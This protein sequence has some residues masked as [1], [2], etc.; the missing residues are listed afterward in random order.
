MV[1][2]NNISYPYSTVKI[3][4][5]YSLAMPSSLEYDTAR[6]V[7]VLAYNLP[8]VRFKKNKTYTKDQFLAVVFHSEF[9]TF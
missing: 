8:N 5:Q 9:K 7:E 2:T 6:C 4:I 1:D 3:Y